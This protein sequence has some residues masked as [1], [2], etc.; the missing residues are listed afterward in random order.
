MGIDIEKFIDILAKEVADYKVPIIDLMG[1]QT[2]EPFRI[3]VATILS[4][5]TKDE[6][7]AAACKRLFKKA[8]DVN[9]LAGLSRQEISDLIY[10][11]G[12]YT[13]KSGYLE[14]L[15]KAMEAFDGKVPQNIDDL[16]TLPGVGRK[17]ANLVMS[18]AFKKDAICVD[19]HVHR[20]MNLWEYVD[21]RN[22]LETEMALRKKLPPK[23]WQRVNAILVAFGQ[24]TCRP[25][26]SH[27]D[28][29]V[30]ESMCPKKGAKPRKNMAKA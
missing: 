21:T 18:V 9:A 14:R 22:P 2:E 13:S 8:P 1:A 20:I 19:T 10:P 17:T 26:G 24:G 16:V 7:T 6:T 30:L 23:L 27:C 5:R 11:V 12:F 4:A 29:C 3:L 28:V 25:V 15:P